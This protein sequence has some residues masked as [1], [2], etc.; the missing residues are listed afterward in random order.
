V[1]GDAVRDVTALRAAIARNGTAAPVSLGV[2]RGGSESVLEVTPVL[3][4]GQ[5]RVPVIGVLIAGQYVFPLDITIELENVGGPSAGMMFALGIIDKLTPDSLAGGADV[6][7]TGTIGADGAVGPIGGIVQKMYGAR[8]AGAEWFLSPVANC[9][10][11]AG[12]V[13]GDLEV[14]SVSTLDEAIGVLQTIAEKG[15]LD[16]LARCES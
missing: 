12:N 6:A 9:N 15:D 16:E 13:P 2:I 3:S 14:F 10:E 4:E 7:G 11:V 5:D 1:N 8:D